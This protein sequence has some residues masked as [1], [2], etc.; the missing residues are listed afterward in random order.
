MGNP[1]D[2]TKEEITDVVIRQS[3]IPIMLVRAD[4][5]EPFPMVPNQPYYLRSDDEIAIDDDPSAN[6]SMAQIEHNGNNGWG[7]NI[8]PESSIH[9]LRPTPDHFGI[10]MGVVFDDGVVNLTFEWLRQDDED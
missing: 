7:W 8:E 10:G 3:D 6:V 1:T 2:D 9:H 4:G 5:T